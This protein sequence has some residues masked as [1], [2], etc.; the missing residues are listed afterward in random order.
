VS[1]QKGQES[2][3]SPQPLDPLT[4]WVCVVALGR[5]G[6]PALTNPWNTYAGDY[7]DDSLVDFGLNIRRDW[8]DQGN[9]YLMSHALGRLARG[10][11]HGQLQGL[12]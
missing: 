7:S 9:V 5:Y 1:S 11:K 2:E 12:W 10:C 8:L 3:E 6:Q 4:Q